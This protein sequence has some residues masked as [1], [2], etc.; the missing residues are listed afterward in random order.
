MY[1]RI[2]KRDNKG[3]PAY[4]LHVGANRQSPNVADDRWVAEGHPEIV[5]IM[6]PE[7]EQHINEA[8]FGYWC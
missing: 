8:Y 5:W 4:K 2:S 3:E 7:T 1:L 6:G